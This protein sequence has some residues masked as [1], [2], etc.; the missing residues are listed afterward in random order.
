MLL[1]KLGTDENTK[2]TNLILQQQ[3]Q[4]KTTKQKNKKKKT[5]F[6]KTI[7][8]LSSIFDER[9]GLCHTKYKCLN[10]RKQEDEDFVSFAGNVNQR[11]KRFNLKY[12]SIAMFKCLV[13][14]QGLTEQLRLRHS[15]ANIK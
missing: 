15:F 4:K 3:Q 12:L 6:D 1:Q 13:F 2:Y 14:V 11:Y 7:K 10:L 9:S 8:C 5:T